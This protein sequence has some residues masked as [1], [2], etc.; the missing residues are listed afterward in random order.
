MFSTTAWNKMFTPAFAWV[1]V[2]I[3]ILIFLISAIYVFNPVFH[4][5]LG[6]TSG[7]GTSMI[8]QIR[9]WLDGGVA[10][11][12]LLVVVAIIVSWVITKK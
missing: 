3:M 1:I 10:G 5:D 9:D 12:V 2:G 4:S 11:S 8:G 7:E 6:V